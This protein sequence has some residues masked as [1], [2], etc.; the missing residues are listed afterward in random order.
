MAESPDQ[1]SR[2]GQTAYDN[3]VAGTSE[4]NYDTVFEPS[5]VMQGQSPN[6]TSIT[7]YTAFPNTGDIDG[8]STTTLNGGTVVPFKGE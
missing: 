3:M 1:Q 5:I 6:F 2:P 7:G 4:T 8:S